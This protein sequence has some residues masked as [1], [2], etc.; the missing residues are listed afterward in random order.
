MEGLTV[1]IRTVALAGAVTSTSTGLLGLL[2]PD[3]L[4]SAV[5]IDPD[6]VVTTVIR[7]VCA[8]YLG[9]GLLAWLA[10]NM[11]DVVAWRAISI[12]N[13]VSWGLSACALAIG[14]ASGVGAAWVWILVAVQ[15]AY[16]VAWA[17]ALVRTRRFASR[18]A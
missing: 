4:A 13:A 16:A 12:A 6:A 2:I 9:Y 3:L 11:T 18:L 1:G 15:V 17:S 10:R 7:L 5:G 8:A 14:L